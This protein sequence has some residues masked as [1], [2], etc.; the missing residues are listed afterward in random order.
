MTFP[1]TIHKRTQA[2]TLLEVMIASALFFIAI[3]SVL[4]LSA[5]SLKAARSLSP[6]HADINEL[7]LPLV[8]TN[9]F[10]DDHL[11]MVSGEFENFP[12]HSWSQEIVPWYTNGFFRVNFQIMHG[13]QLE[14]ETAIYLYKPQ[15]RITQTF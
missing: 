7:V 5:R 11:G 2:F 1:F 13:G 10:T 14:S 9:R 4:Q 8:L 6:T 15:S 3:F 12:Q